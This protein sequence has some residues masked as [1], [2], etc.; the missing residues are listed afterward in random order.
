MA[1]PLSK[2]LRTPALGGTS[3]PKEI[4]FVKWPGDIKLQQQSAILYK[5]LKVPSAINQ[6]TPALDR[7]IATQL[8]TLAHKDR[9]ETK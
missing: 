2:G 1:N 3:C 9:P 6:F 7:Q 4:S 8:L 5:W